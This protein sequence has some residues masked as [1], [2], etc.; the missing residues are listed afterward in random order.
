MT[1]SPFSCYLIGADTL[2]MECGDVLLREGHD[3]CGV[4]TS[5]PRVRMWAEGHGVP[6]VDASGDYGAAIADTPFDYLFAITHLAII[7]ED[8]L[9]LPRKMAVNFHDGPLPRY[10]GLNAPVWALMA[11]ESEYGITWHEI[12]P[13][14]DEGDILRQERFQV[15]DDETALSLN[16][17]CMVAALDSFPQL[18]AD[19]ATGTVTRTPQDLSVRSYFGRHDRPDAACLI[20]WTEPATRV[21]AFVRAL[22]FGPYLNPVGVPKSV[23]AGSGGEPFVV[24]GA[25]VVDHGR[26]AAAGTVVAVNEDGVVVAAGEG[27]VALTGARTLDGEELDPPALAVRFD[28][29]EGTT[30]ET[31]ASETGQALSRLDGEL[32]RHEG[33]WLRRLRRAEAPV[34]PQA[35]TDT[36]PGGR[37]QT[38]PVTLPEGFFD[39]WADRADAAVLAAWAVYLARTGRRS[40][41]HLGLARTRPDSAAEAWYS[42]VVPLHLTPDPDASFLTT[43]DA[44]QEALERTGGHGTFLRDLLLREPDLA[45][46]H[47]LAASLLPVGASLGTQPPTDA[48]LWLQVGDPQAVSIHWDPARLDPSDA[49]AVAAALSACLDAAHDEPG[50]S[51]TALPLL[52]DATRDRVVSEWNDTTSLW[53][54]TR[55]VHQLFEAQVDRTPDATAVVFRG[56][57]LTYRE[58]DERANQLAHWLRAR[59]VGPDDLVGVHVSRSTELLVATLGVL[60]AGAAYV[61][62]DPEFP[63]DRIA[64]MIEDSGAPVVVTEAAQASS[65]EQLAPSVV[66]IDDDWEEIGRESIDRPSATATP[67]NLAYAIYTSGSTGRPKG[68]LVEHRNVASFFAGM[69]PVIEHDRPGTWLAVTS[70]SFDISVLE[71][72]WTLAR[73]FTVVV[74]AEDHASATGATRVDPAVAAR[75]MD[76]GLFMWGNDDGPGPQKY[77]LMMEAARYF[78]ENDFDSVWTPERHFHAFGGP[79]PNPSVTGAALAAVTR[80]VSIRSGSCVSPLHH[81]IRIAEE[82]AVVD[83]LSDGRVGLSFAAG[84]QPNDFILRP[85]SFGRAKEVMLEQID[86]V[87]RLWRGEAVE[88]PSPTGKT[89]EVVS[90]PRPVQPELPFW[91]TTAGNPESYRAAGAL[92]ANVLTHLLGQSLDEVG[93]K[94]AIYRKAREDAGLD[95][96]KGVVTLMLHT[97]V[98]HDD[99]EVRELVRGPMKDY[100]AASMKLVLG[101]AWSFPAFKRPGGADARPEDVDLASLSPE[102]NDIIL[103]FAFERYFETSGLFG[104]PETCLRMVNSC[105]AIGVDEIACLLDYGVDT[106]RALESLPLLKTVRDAAN[107][108]PAAGGQEAADTSLAAQIER[109]GVTHLQC[110]P[111]MARLILA[112]P[113]AREA[114]GRV[115]HLMIGGEALPPAL[116]R[117]LIQVSGTSLTNMYGP[118]ETTIWSSTHRVAADAAE[119]PIGRPIANTRMYVLDRYRQPLPPG[120]PGDLFIGGPG[121]TRGYHRREELTS[122]RFVPDPFVE[123]GGRMYATGD[124]AAFRSDGVIDF[125]G[126]VDHQ[127]KIRGYRI[128]LGEIEAALEERADVLSAAVI[129][130]EDTPGDQRLVAYVVADEGVADAQLRDHLRERLPEYMVPGIYVPLDRMPLTPNGKIDRRALPEPRAVQRASGEAVYTAPSNE[131]EAAIARAWQETLGIE[132]VGVSENFFDIGGH[133]LLVVQLHRKLT[134]AIPQTLSLVD[135]Y[136]FPTIRALTDHLGEADGNGA[137]AAQEGIDRAERRRMARRRRS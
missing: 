49:G 121:V 36:A 18:V 62:L 85:E 134:E 44:V 100:L 68:V 14:V 106:D 80:N 111:S 79:F 43:V 136:R 126:R 128:E 54:D 70:L 78:D 131:L 53:D 74:H 132:R 77:R 76:F 130:R 99:D 97:F 89:V 102:E 3:I 133:S 33:V 30:L 9:D 17:R 63:A 98:G 8:V 57:R 108:P 117:E 67:D 84:W 94:I 105:K 81:P 115:E 82:W 109:H 92:G 6:V 75:P 73:G 56:D 15:A 7:P 21:D 64:F 107:R 41:V 19:L 135:L 48:L 116:A 59:D 16:T 104:T 34:V 137:V 22:T 51:W 2:L 29:S 24:T 25:V 37:L 1:A 50:R 129:V 26:E 90:L 28:L 38:T 93:E 120:V 46:H 113:P 86:V 122:E 40:D 60:K 10:A 39:R 20:D 32:R 61:P 103:D 11:G 27:F 42:D 35:D 45:E 4:I 95:P 66:R 65:V 83:N 114:L 23:V 96:A 31:P 125:L 110:T 71:L 119:I 118:T 101:F 55:C 127:V 124:L 72:F 91:V 87:R 112:D 47:N 88:F 12:T 5:T 58:L 52:D 13:G 123:D 69:D